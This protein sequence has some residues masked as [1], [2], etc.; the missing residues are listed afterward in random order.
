[1]GDLVDQR[2]HAAEH[3]EAAGRHGKN[4][5]GVVVKPGNGHTAE[6]A[7]AENFADG[8]HR[9]QRQR[10]AET[11]AET[12]DRGINHTVLVGVHFGSAEDDAVDDDQRQIHTQRLI[13][14]IGICL[15]DQLNDG[16][17]AGDD[18]DVARN[19][20]RVRNDF[21]QRGNCHVG[22]NQNH[23]RRNAHAERRRDRCGNCQRRAGAEHQNQ[24]R[25]FLDEA[26]EKILKL[27]HFAA[28][29]HTS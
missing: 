24:N 9:A 19:A 17:E 20:D 26:L 12:V 29:L 11:H 14:L 28:S 4:A 15:H 18:R 27:R 21:P 6:G 7:G 8:R 3:E 25:V 16:H 13:Q 23:R 10:K 22:K 2:D 1:M 5:D